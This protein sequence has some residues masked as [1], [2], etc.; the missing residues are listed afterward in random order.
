MYCYI[1]DEF[2]QDKRYEKDLL[3][4][5][6]RLTDLGIE[7][8]IIRLALFR[9][10]S[11]LV[12]DAIVRGA[13][14]I[15]AVGGDATV[16]KILD[17]VTQSGAVLGLIPI[18]EPSTL[19]KIFGL[20]GG[21]ASCDILSQRIIETI[22]LG[23]VNDRSFLHCLS[24]PHFSAEMVCDGQYRLQPKEAGALEVRN[25]GGPDLS[26]DSMADPR[27]GVLD[28]VVRVGTKRGFFRRKRVGETVLPLRSL[29][30]R[31]KEPIEIFA[32][33]EALSATDFEITIVPNRLPVI[34][35][36]KRLF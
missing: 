20:P 35:G 25:I 9:D 34:T 17:V 24:A 11:E 19:A 32:D 30:I 16:R 3:S 27:D 21:I 33:G 18:G 23:V 7:G 14:T 13:T 28:T 8:K 12:R 31:S 5:E 36:R 6:T 15:I 26:K 1:Y 29:Q 2:V 22:D 10:P 4:L